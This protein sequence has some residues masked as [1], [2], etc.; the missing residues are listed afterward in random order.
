MNIVAFRSALNCLS[1]SINE[2][3]NSN[4]QCDPLNVCITGRGKS[5]VNER[6]DSPA[7]RFFQ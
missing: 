4:M 2:T 6:R 5:V 1:R 3:G 7:S